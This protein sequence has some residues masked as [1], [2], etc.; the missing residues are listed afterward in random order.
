[1]TCS[2]NEIIGNL[3]LTHLDHR[4]TD[5]DAC[6]GCLPLDPLLLQALKPYTTT[7]IRSIRTPLC[8]PL[9]HTCGGHTLPELEKNWK[10]KNQLP[11][12]QLPLESL[13]QVAWHLLL[14]LME[15]GL[16]SLPAG[17]A[18]WDLHHPVQAAC[19]LEDGHRW[20]SSLMKHPH[21]I[22]PVSF[23][24]QIARLFNYFSVVRVP[25]SSLDNNIHQ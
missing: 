7:K 10:F 8:S 20:L 23:F 9:Y 19:T 24:F 12:L 15:A 1:M 22:K 6:K 11:F 21:S 17:P 14:G 5:K 25:R 13:D 18:C 3:L 2:E 4:G 16:P